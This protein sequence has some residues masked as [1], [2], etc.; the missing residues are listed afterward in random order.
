[1][2]EIAKPSERK[3]KVKNLALTKHEKKYI[4]FILKK[5]N[6]KIIRD[7]YIRVTGETLTKSRLCR[8]RKNAQQ[9]SRVVRF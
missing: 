9:C 8:L 5:V 6:K 3:F 1:M 2:D 4:S 7:E